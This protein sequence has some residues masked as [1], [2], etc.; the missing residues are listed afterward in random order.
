MYIIIN[1]N[2]RPIIYITDV[3]NILILYNP[4]ITD[5]YTILLYI[6]CI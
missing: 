5:V 1:K 3:R 2:I 6:H 4:C